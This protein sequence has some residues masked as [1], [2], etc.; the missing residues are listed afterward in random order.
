MKEVILRNRDAFVDALEQYTI[1]DR[2]K[3]ILHNVEYVVLIGPAAAGRNTIIDELKKTGNYHQVVSDTTRPPKLR[4]GNMEQHGVNYF[5]RSEEELLT[6][7]KNGEFLEAELIHNQQVSGTSIRELEASINEGK[8][9]INEV[10]FGGAKNVIRAKPDSNVFAVFPPSFDEWFSRFA[11][12]EE[13]TKQE[14]ANRLRTLQQVI[15]TVKEDKRIRVVI[16][17]S[18]VHAAEL[19]D[20]YM[21][22]AKQSDDD[23]HS[24]QELLTGYVHK[25]K[26][27]L[28]KLE[29]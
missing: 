21:N 15:A 10:E 1:S 28:N 24:I 27:M 25:T 2:S 3:K 6:D 17:D 5:F 4:D 22:G 9:A 7:L 11:A 23:K 29:N 26:Q 19:L 12:R 16:N 14:L 13:I 20:S 18:Y 8:I